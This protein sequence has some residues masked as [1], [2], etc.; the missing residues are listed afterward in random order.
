MIFRF[1]DNR[2]INVDLIRLPL[3]VNTIGHEES[4]APGRDY[5]GLYIKPLALTVTQAAEGLG[6]TRKT[7][8]LLLN[9]HAGI[10]PEMAI[11]LSQSFGRSARVGFS[12]KCN[13]TLLKSGNRARASKPPGFMIQTAY[14]HD[15]L[16]S[17]PKRKHLQRAS[18]GQG[19]CR[20]RPSHRCTGAFQ[21]KGSKVFNH[22]LLSRSTLSPE[23]INSGFL[24]IIRVSGGTDSVSH[25][26]PPI[27]ERAPITVSAAQDGCSRVDDHVILDSGVAF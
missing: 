21:V 18:G 27:I 2:A 7:L 19:I 22:G 6:V 3:G 4:P 8:S 23:K 11:R 5:P 14:D 10:S 26:L 1:E 17:K 16:L 24:M 9:G 13:T 20:T 25:T 15:T 12:F